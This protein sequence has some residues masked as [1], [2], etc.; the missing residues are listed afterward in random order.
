V[1]SQGGMALR[2]RSG[3]KALKS[4]LG[5]KRRWKCIS[6][7]GLC[8]SNRANQLLKAKL[9]GWQQLSGGLEGE[10][11]WP[12]A[13]TALSN[14]HFGERVEPNGG[15]SEGHSAPRRAVRVESTSGGHKAAETRYGSGRG[16][17]FEG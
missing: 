14:V 1:F 2:T 11:G 8:R 17:F 13:T 3:S 6:G 9:V 15:S 12:K 5:F 4:R 7:N 10:I 16:E